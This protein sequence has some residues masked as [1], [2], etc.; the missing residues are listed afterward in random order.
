MH[1]AI[2]FV[3]A[4]VLAL[5]SLAHADV[6]SVCPTLG[7]GVNLYGQ[8]IQEQHLKGL[9][10][11][12]KTEGNFVV[13]PDL[14]II[15]RSEQPVHS[16]T[17]ITAAG[18]RRIVNGNEVQRLPSARAP[19]FAHVYELLDRAMMGDWSLIEKDFTVEYTG[20]RQSWR[21]VLT[22]LRSE[23]PLAAR[24]TSVVLT[25]DGRIDT[26]DINRVNGDS[27]H[28]AFLNQVVSNTPLADPDAHL[29][30]DKWK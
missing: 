14:G 30:H 5:P 8:F 20:D 1:R 19:A 15:W 11:P 4:A 18:V 10:A 7:T 16:V 21:V 17:V 9:T 26:V 27:E 23:G 12:L 22:P 2:V 13:A 28:V 3:L 25:G 6:A 29:L 24:L